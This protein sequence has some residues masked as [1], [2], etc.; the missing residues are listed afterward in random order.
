MD[1]SDG[2]DRTKISKDKD[3]IPEKSC[4]ENQKSTPETFRDY[5]IKTYPLVLKLN[6]D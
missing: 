5:V 2:K 3:T 6:C 1:A 4:F